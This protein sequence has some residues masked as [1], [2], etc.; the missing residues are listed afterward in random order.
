M[1]RLDEFTA[2]VDAVEPRLD[3]ATRTLKVRASYNGR[4]ELIPGSS[5]TVTLDEGSR[6]GIFVPSEALSGDARGAILF[7]FKG[8]VVQPA[9]VTIGLREASRIEVLSGVRA[10]DTILV[11]GATRVGPGKPVKIARIIPSP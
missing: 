3:P 11:A 1:G 2:R 4:V 9:R 6:A 7:L 8:G 10:G 5:V